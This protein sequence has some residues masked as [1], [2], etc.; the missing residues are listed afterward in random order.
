M[1]WMR[2]FDTVFIKNNHIY[3]EEYNMPGS[4]EIYKDKAGEF[5]FRLKASNGEIVLA[6]EGYKAKASCK[7][8]IES[9]KKNAQ[10]E[11]SFEQTETK[12]GKARF[13][14]RA[15]N[16]QIIGTSQPYSSSS[17]CSNGIKCIMRDAPDAVVKDLTV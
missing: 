13:N 6:S 10:S 2:G 3:N 11:A 1:L 16:K 7:K 4:F 9:V 8:G 17:S 5:R 12:T 15:A 14:L